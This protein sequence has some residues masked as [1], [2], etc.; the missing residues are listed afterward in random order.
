MKQ[1]VSIVAILVLVASAGQLAYLYTARDGELSTSVSMNEGVKA[2]TPD[3][4]LPGLPHDLEVGV[5]QTVDFSADAISMQ[6]LTTFERNDQYRDWLLF[7]VI[8]AQGL[9]AQT[10][11]QVLFDLPPIRRGYVR[12]LGTFEYG[13]TRSRALDKTT[14]IALVPASRSEAQRRD[15]LSHVADLQRKNLGEPFQRMEIVEYSLDGEHAMARLTRLPDVSYADLFSA[16]YGYV[17]KPLASIA[18]FNDFMASVDNLT[19]VTKTRQG[20][21]AGGRK[22]LSGHRSPIGVEEVAAIWQSEHNNRVR[23]ENINKQAQ[24]RLDALNARYEAMRAKGASVSSLKSNYNA[25]YEQLET[26]RLQEYRA[27]R[28]LAGSGFSLDSAIRFPE[29]R[30][31]FEVIVKEL[32]AEQA[33]AI[34]GDGGIQAVVDGLDNQDIGPYV[35]ISRQLER[36]NK[37]FKLGMLMKAFKYGCSYQA[38]RYDGDLQ[39]TSAGMTLFY[40]D[41][42]AKLWTIDFVDSSPRRNAILDFVDDPHVKLSHV[43]DKEAEEL[44]KARLWFGPSNL[45]YQVANDN[46]TMLFAHTATRIY[47]AGHNEATPSKEVQT[48]AFLA[49]AIEW[50]NDHYEEVADYEP[51]Y[52]RLNEIMKWSVVI[53][54]LNQTANAHPLDYLSSVTVDRSNV[55]P[56][57]AQRNKALRFDQWHEVGFHKAGYAGTTTEAL[58]LLRGPVTAGGVSLAMRDAAARPSIA[59]GV[60]QVLRRSNIQYSSDMNAIRTAEGQ[61]SIKTFDETQFTLKPVR[62]FKAVNDALVRLKPVNEDRF[63][64]ITEAKKGTKLRS[65]STQVSDSPFKRTV[66]MQSDAVRIESRM[67]DV[68][69]N[70][71]SIERTANG[72]RIG[73]HARK[74][75]RVN[76]FARDLSGADPIAALEGNPMI[77][78]VLQVQGKDSVF[79]RFERGGEWAEFAREK[80]PRVDIDPDWQLRTA[81]LEND[82][83]AVIQARMVPDTQMSE[84]LGNGHFMIKETTDGKH[85]IVA[86]PDQTAPIEV[87]AVHTR[88][89][90]L[91]VWVDRESDVVH[92]IAQDASMNPLAIANSLQ[93]AD[94]DVIRKAAR[95]SSVKELTL[96]G[97]G[98]AGSEF[99]VNLEQGNLRK[100]ALHLADDP[101]AARRAIDEKVATAVRRTDDIHEQLGL[102]EA[103]HYLDGLRTTYGD[104]P[105][106]ALRRGLVELERGRTDAAVEALNRAPRLGSMDRQAFYDEVKA[107][108]AATADP[109][110]DISRFSDFVHFQEHI[111][112]QADSWIDRL[113][114]RVKDERFDFDATL[115]RMPSESQIPGAMDF[116][117]DEWVIYRQTNVSLDHLDWNN[118]FDKAIPDIVSGKLGKVVE[119][120]DGDIAQYRPSVIWSVDHQTEFTPIKAKVSQHIPRPIPAPPPSCD[121]AANDPGCGN[122]NESAAPRR[123]R[124]L[125]VMAN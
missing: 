80:A 27:Q 52:Q 89:G 53:A 114:P 4:N 82:V 121:Q 43:Y 32:P 94:L 51:Q 59:N 26:Q 101:V 33:R 22:F 13:E 3:N 78:S 14:V 83:T 71:L 31:L 9:D 35:L 119:L 102:D 7:A 40:T 62:E 65:V 28:I 24:E 95:G 29:L 56:D 113:T 86:I 6:D 90:D 98:A 76:A 37:T 104:R 18:E 69:L 55:F 34:F 92:I 115:R 20:L 57:W 67:A 88:L 72:F 111:G 117:A 112:K 81:T 46:G 122:V 48:S 19:F 85:I 1:L 97:E 42:I 64:I 105:E 17:E 63:L 23:E 91:S 93:R 60:D 96:P 36:D 75:D 124:I 38:A 50:W 87:M 12:A 16:Q 21:I 107:R 44:S 47:S 61:I 39:G 100:A 125:L 5:P 99:V 79:A 103:L 109:H 108:I 110:S 11:S 66:L 74:M 45:G 106:I 2:D 58:P 10:F 123:Q 120:P 15:D 30:K 73:L 25:E 70:D 116:R 77:S 118:P 41:L 49:A 8:S 54:W 68:P 84:L